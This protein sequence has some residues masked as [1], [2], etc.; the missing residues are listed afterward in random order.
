MLWND[1]EQQ[2]YKLN[3]AMTQMGFKNRST[4]L[5]PNS[6]KK[7][8]E[9]LVGKRKTNLVHQNGKLRGQANKHSH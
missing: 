1:N 4:F 5:N 3:K 2:K 8:K 7:K 9:Y 6:K